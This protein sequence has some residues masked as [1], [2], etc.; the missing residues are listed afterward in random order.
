MKQ[1]FLMALGVA[2]A[3]AAAG[4]LFLTPSNRVEKQ[5]PV[6]T[7]DHSAASHSQTTAAV[8]RYQEVSEVGQLRPTL[9]E[10]QFFGKAREAYR[11]ARE[12][13][14]TLAQLPCYCHCDR[15]FGHK[16]LHTCFED[17]H[18]SQCAVCVDEAL[19]A[20]K[21]QKEGKLT[22]AEI[23]SQIIEKYTASQ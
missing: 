17:D 11:V 15:S 22:P 6:T 7:E 3:L 16:S 18:A 20:Y 12:I 14:Q 23:R 5:R 10:T 8:P 9:T 2:L 1:K 21:L 13:P 4:L 19:L